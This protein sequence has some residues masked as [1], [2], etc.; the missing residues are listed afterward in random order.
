[1]GIEPEVLDR[2]RHEGDHGVAGA[3]SIRQVKG[4]W[5][6][7]RLHGDVTLAVEANLSVAAVAAIA[8]Q[9][10]AHLHQQMPYLAEVTIQIQPQAPATIL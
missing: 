1:D 3:A 2:L 9:L 10:K 5:L 4:R 8:A 6:G 7:H